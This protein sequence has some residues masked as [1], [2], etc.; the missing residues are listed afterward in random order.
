MARNHLWAFPKLASGH[1]C[2]RHLVYASKVLIDTIK[3]R[4]PKVKLLILNAPPRHGKT[5]Q[6]PIHGTPFI[7]G[8]YPEKKIIIASYAAS[9]SER[10]SAKA[11]DLFAEWGPVLWNVK[12]HNAVFGRSL[13]QTEKGGEVL[14]V[15]LDGG[16]SGFGADILFVD[17]YHKNREQ[18]E[19]ALQRD[20]AWTWWQSVAGTRIHPNATIVF[21]ATRWHDDDIIGRIL[22]QHKEEGARSPFDL[23]YINLPAIAEEDDA[24]GR[25]PG[26]A[27]WPWWMDTERLNHV[28]NTVGPYEWSALFQGH[29]TSRG[30][31]L[32]KSDDFR[33]YTV[34]SLS[35]DF[36]C[37]RKD[38]AEPLRISRKSLMRHAYIDPALEVKTTNDPTGMAA[39]GYSREHRIWLL[40]DRKN[41]RIEHH[42]IMDA[43]K[44]FAFKA[45]CSK[46]GIENE[47]IGKILIK[48]SAGNDEIWGKK[49]PF[50]EVPTK[51]L[52][53]YARATPM[54]SY[55][56]A[57]RVFFPKNAP[58]LSE[59]ETSLVKFPSVAHD[60][61]ID[62][63]A[64]AQDMESKL[65]LAEIMAGKR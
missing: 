19:S 15:G 16:T 25:E 44:L 23:T 1:K 64:M 32:F 38:I 56:E 26:E 7:L 13:W 61:D 21:F 57:E 60:E 2:P 46:I 48:Q 34:D 49:I 43:I 9:L 12:P 41:A 11:R 47:K 30:G 36:L 37:W 42:K 22:L 51:G 5:E 3:R 50:F 62:V 59:Y 58:W 54:A 53:K 31:S 55:I 14:A 39:W 10:H 20:K 45:E 24:L 33:Y 6:F 29:P 28:K 27:L 40:L 8:H 65:T 4:S 17:D 18:A 35:S 63:T 52:D